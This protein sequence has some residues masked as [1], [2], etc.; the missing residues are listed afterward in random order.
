[1]AGAGILAIT[2]A[3]LAVLFVYSAVVIVRQDYEYTLE[4]FGRYMQTLRRG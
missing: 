2:L 3:A 4:R 1:M